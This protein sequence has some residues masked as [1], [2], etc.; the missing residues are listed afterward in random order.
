[1]SFSE[2][3][4]NSIL[5]TFPKFELSYENITHK[6]VHNADILLAIPEGNKGFVWFTCYN[7]ENICFLLEMDEKNKIKNIKRMLVSFIDSL[8]LGTIFYGS[9]FIYNNISCFAIE[10]IY[11]YKGNNYIYTPYSNK[12]HL[13]KQI[14]NTEI[15]QNI[16]NHNFTIFGLPLV[17]MDFN[18]LLNDIQKLPY[19]I[20]QIKFRFFEKKNTRKIMTMQYFKPSIISKNNIQKEKQTAVFKIMADIEPDIYNLFIYKNGVDE[21]YDMAFIPDFKT[22]VMMNKL[23]RNIK[24]N[25]NLDTIEESDNELDFEDVREDK[26]VYLDKSFNLICEYNYKFKRWVPIS[27]VGENAQIASSIIIK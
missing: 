16:L 13:F 19:K 8:A 2:F 24:E 27:L 6:K 11:Y 7:N 23:F 18:L 3:H 22:S 4:N 1:M 21:Y 15:S 10:D 26:Y 12:L 9:L 14:F 17:Y 25:D 20:S 5:K